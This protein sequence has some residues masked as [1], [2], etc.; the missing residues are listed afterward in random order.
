MEFQVCLFNESSAAAVYGIGTYIRQMVT[1]LSASEG[2]NL[3]VVNSMCTDVKEFVV[4]EKEG[5]REISIPAPKNHRTE[6]EYN[7]YYRNVW[8]LIGGLINRD[9]PVIFHLNYHQEFPLISH[10]RAEL[11]E[12]YFC[13]TIHYQMWCFAMQGNVR[14]YKEIIHKEPDSLLPEEKKVL[15]EYKKECTLFEAV[16]SVICLSEFT[17]Q[18]ILKEYF[19]PP[20]KVHII[21]NG[22]KDTY[23]SLLPSEQLALR[24]RLL[25][26]DDEKIILF[27]GRLYSD[28]GL[29]SLIRAFYQVHAHVKSRLV[30]IGDGNTPPFQ[31]I[32]KG[33]WNIVTFTGRLEQEDLFDFYQVADVGVMPSFYEQCSFVA[34]EMMMMGLPLVFTDAPGLGEMLPDNAPL[35]SIY[36]ENEKCVIREEELADSILQCLKNPNRISYR[37]NYLCRYTFD[38]MRNAYLNFYAESVHKVRSR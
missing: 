6:K 5:Y 27:V 11:P 17:R 25:I 26:D 34:I 4:K 1:I 14:K 30:I 24:H 38:V 19:L 33:F 15:Q 36:D 32:C 2:I 12:S 13:Y 16:D 9:I 22:I 31:K 7:R 18:L 21:C 8:R 37:Q 35:I 28:K 23:V 10:I 29:E 3:M 20:S